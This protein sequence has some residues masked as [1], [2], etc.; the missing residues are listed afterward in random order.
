MSGLSDLAGHNEQV[1]RIN[2]CAILFGNSIS[3]SDNPGPEEVQ[4]DNGCRAVDGDGYGEWATP[5]QG[6]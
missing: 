6:S 3:V 2:F 5:E 4:E 1:K